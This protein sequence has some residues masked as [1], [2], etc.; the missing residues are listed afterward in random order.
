MGNTE[1]ERHLGT[2]GVVERM[3]LKWNLKTW[4]G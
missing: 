2:P 4:D 1:G 3:I